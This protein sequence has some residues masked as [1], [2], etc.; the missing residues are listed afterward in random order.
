MSATL[1]INASIPRIAFLADLIRDSLRY[2]PDNAELKNLIEESRNNNRSLVN[3]VGTYAVTQTTHYRM[4]AD[5]DLWMLFL[6]RIVE[7][8]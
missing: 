6:A 5:H 8:E 1:T 2:N 3:A 4:E 7:D